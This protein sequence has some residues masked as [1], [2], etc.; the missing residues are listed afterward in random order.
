MSCAACDEAQEQDMTETGLHEATYVRVG[1][2]NVLIS[3]CREHLG[4][5]IDRL[6]EASRAR[7]NN[8]GQEGRPK[9]AEQ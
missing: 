8:D 5:L 1:R 9:G 7:E 3:G 2:A 4:E 6:R